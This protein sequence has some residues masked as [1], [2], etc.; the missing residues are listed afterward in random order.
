MSVS[1]KTILPLLSEVHNMQ[2]EHLELMLGTEPSMAGAA[3]TARILTRAD[4]HF[5]I[6][7][8]YYGAKR[9]ML[10]QCNIHLDETDVYF[11]SNG[12]SFN[13]KGDIHTFGLRPIREMLEE[14]ISHTGIELAY[15]DTEQKQQEQTVMLQE[16]H[17]VLSRGNTL[18]LHVKTE[19]LV[20]N[21]LYTENPGKTHMIQLYGLHPQENI[22]YVGDHFLLDSSGAVLGY[23]GPSS[24]SELLEGT[25]EYAYMD[26]TGEAAMDEQQILSI[27]TAHLD[28]FLNGQDHGSAGAWGIAAYRRLVHDMKMMS[29]LEGEAFAEACDTVYYHLR[30]ESL[31]HLMRYTDHFIQKYQHR[32]GEQAEQLQNEITALNQDTKRHLLQLYK[33]GLQNSPHKMESYIQRSTELLDR[34]EQHLSSLHQALSRVAV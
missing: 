24:L 34:I 23:S 32:L 30:I 13:Y 1:D 6:N 12:I 16:W 8:C 28:E 9:A 2:P 15:V 17:D 22:A 7:H 18:L 31:S 10:Q 26:H 25:V 20:Y 21:P 19:N 3:T 33:M 11:L 14:W 29:L 5:V 4:D 27:C